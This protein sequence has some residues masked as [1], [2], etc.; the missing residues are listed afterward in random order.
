MKDKEKEV[1]Q[2]KVKQGPYMQPFSNYRDLLDNL[3]SDQ[4][5]SVELSDETEHV[6]LEKK[7][8]RKP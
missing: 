7:Y 2:Q 4:E 6:E 8:Q 3:Y 5:L 1:Y